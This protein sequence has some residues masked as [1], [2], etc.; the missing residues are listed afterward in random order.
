M[1]PTS[2]I[3]D[4]LRAWNEG[5]SDAL[6]RLLPL[7]YQTLH[8]IAGN[9]MRRERTN[10][11]LQPTELVSEAFLRLSRGVDVEW[12]NRAHF[13]GVASRAMRQILVEHAR[14]HNRDKRGAGVTHVTLSQALNRPNE[15][16]TL[17]LTHLDDALKSLE[18]FAPRQCRIVEM[19]FFG[20][21]N[22][23][24]ISAV[25]EI[26]PATVKREWSVARKWLYRE[27]NGKERP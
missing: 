15:N 25:L 20:G 19:K 18:R 14:S 1:Q 6:D 27:L 16:E 9:H 11:T 24:E 3:T 23:E 8:K 13:Y 10:H 2:E 17:E 21:L 5:A 22:V 26:S 4:L 7:I 12:K